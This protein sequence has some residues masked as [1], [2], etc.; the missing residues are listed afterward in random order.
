MKSLRLLFGAHA[1]PIHRLLFLA[2]SALFFLLLTGCDQ[3]GNMRYQPSYG[4][5]DQSAFFPDGKSARTYPAGI[6]AHTDNSPNDPTIT[7]LDDSGKPVSGF[8]QGVTVDQALV[9]KG[10]AR[11]NIYCIPCH[12]A[13]GKADGVV[14]GFGF[15]KPVDLHSDQAKALTNGDIFAVIQNGKNKMFSYGYRVKPDERW[16]VIAYIRAL[17][18]KNGPVDPTKLTADELSQIGK[19]P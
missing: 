14:I 2:V 7:G 10:Q 17:Q 11:Y 6:V 3:T 1:A 9:A 15:P 4:P 12:G 16:S 18:I 13:E 8:P 5:L 19:Q